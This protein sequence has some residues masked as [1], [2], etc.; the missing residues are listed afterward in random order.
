MLTKNL[1]EKVC[2]C[3]EDGESGDVEEIIV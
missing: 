1:K 3:L 2:M